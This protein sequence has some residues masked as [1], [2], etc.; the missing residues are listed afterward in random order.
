MIAKSVLH[1]GK[2]VQTMYKKVVEDDE[3]M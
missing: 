3:E 2:A 1:A